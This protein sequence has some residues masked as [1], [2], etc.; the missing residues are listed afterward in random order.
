MGTGFLCDYTLKTYL[1]NTM[2]Y[3]NFYMYSILHKKFTLKINRI[4]SF[5][6]SVPNKPRK[7]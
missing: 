7:K 6:K 5:K 4:S 1:R 3:T 2:I